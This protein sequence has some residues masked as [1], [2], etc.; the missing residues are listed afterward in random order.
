MAG[1]EELKRRLEPIFFDADGNVV[2]PPPSDG[3]FHHTCDSDGSE[4]TSILSN[5]FH[6]KRFVSSR[7]TEKVLILLEIA[8][9]LV[10]LPA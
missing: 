3:S 7:S 8:S 9:S 6:F 1:L 5:W 2:P 4:V 10:F